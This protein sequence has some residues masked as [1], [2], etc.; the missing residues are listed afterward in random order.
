MEYKLTNF[1]KYDY[2]VDIKR[3]SDNK[4]IIQDTVECALI[5]IKNNSPNDYTAAEEYIKSFESKR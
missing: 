4:V 2:Y 5:W 1:C 3:L